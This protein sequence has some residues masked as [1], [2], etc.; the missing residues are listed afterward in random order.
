MT[1]ARTTDQKERDQEDG[2]E[3]QR[4]LLEAQIEIGRTHDVH[5]GRRVGGIGVPRFGGV[6]IDR[7]RSHVAGKRD[8]GG[9]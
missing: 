8:K 2:L 6:D 5:V 3:L 4:N 1:V 7:P 9:R